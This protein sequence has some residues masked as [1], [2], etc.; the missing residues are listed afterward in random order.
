MSTGIVLALWMTVLLL[1]YKSVKS[2]FENDF[3]HEHNKYRAEHGCPSLL[4]DTTLSEECKKYA[5]LLVEKDSLDHSN[6]DYGEN[7]CYTTKNPLTCVKMWYDEIKDYKYESPGFSLI[8]GHFTQLI[9]KSSTTMGVG[10]SS[11]KRK[12]FV[13]ARYKPAGNVAGQ[14]KENVP[15]PKNNFSPD[16]KADWFK[17]CI[18]FSWVFLIWFSWA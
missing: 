17:C 11:G 2:D 9:W 14:F 13:V 15:R 1:L 7:L 8:T 4:L 10:Q 16:C 3:L 5:E 12:N 6:G 18:I